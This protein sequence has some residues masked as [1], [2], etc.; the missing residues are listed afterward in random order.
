MF[1]IH[2]QFH[3]VD[4]TPDGAFL[5]GTDIREGKYVINKWDIR[6]QQEAAGSLYLPGKPKKLVLHGIPIMTIFCGHKS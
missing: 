3:N 1:L 5:L 4:F 6:S 2:T